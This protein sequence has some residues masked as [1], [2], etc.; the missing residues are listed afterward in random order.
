MR[1]TRAPLD[2]D[3][4]DALVSTVPLAAL[5]LKVTDAL[6]CSFFVLATFEMT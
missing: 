1:V 6:F 4:N 3:N 5:D 2:G